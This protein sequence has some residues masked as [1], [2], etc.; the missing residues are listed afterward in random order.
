MVT[1]PN[2]S[3]NQQPDRPAAITGKPPRRAR[4]N[5]RIVSMT[6]QALHGY[7]LEDLSVG[8]SASF[9][10]TVPDAHILTFADLS[11]DPNPVHMV[12]LFSADTPFKR[13]HAPAPPGR[14]PSSP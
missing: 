2:P 1:A 9:E 12:E 5:A 3:V 14:R 11:G 7:Y 13:R 4:R 10:Q 6:F 8:M